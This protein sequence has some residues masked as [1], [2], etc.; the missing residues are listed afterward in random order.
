MRDPKANTTADHPA[1]TRFQR[2]RVLDVA[3]QTATI[4]LFGVNHVALAPASTGNR[5][6]IETEEFRAA[7][8]YRGQGFDGTLVLG[9][10]RGPLQKLT[11]STE[12]GAAVSDRVKEL[13]NQ[14]L[15]RIKNKLLRY[16]VVVEVGL[17]R[18]G[19]HRPAE[20]RSQSS[21]IEY[22]FHALNGSVRVL[23]TDNLEGAALA[24]DASSELLREEEFL[25]FD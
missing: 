12:L 23:L 16:Q 21:S 15:G 4:E 13:A 10:D 6:R 24:F 9:I 5:R 17:P 1:L 25:T 7:I 8:A 3:I 19:V 18:S 2:R 22:S 20:Q 14:L 11:G